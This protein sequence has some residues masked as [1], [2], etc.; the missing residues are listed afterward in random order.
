MKLQKAT[1]IQLVESK[2][3]GKEEARKLVAPKAFSILKNPQGTLDFFRKI[4]SL[5]SNRN[6]DAKIYL[7]V[8]EV[9]YL[10]IDAIMYTLALMYN[11]KRGGPIKYSFSGNLPIAKKPREMMEQCG[12]LNYVKSQNVHFKSSSSYIQIKTGRDSDGEVASEIVDFIKSKYKLEVKQLSFL[13]K[14]LIE[15]MANAKNHA[16]DHPKNLFKK[17]WYVFVEDA[18]GQIK[19]TFLDTGSGI[20]NT[21]RKKMT[22]KVGD[23]LP[24]SLRE[25]LGIYDYRY[26]KSALDAEWRTKTKLLYRGK[27]LPKIN[28]INMNGKIRDLSIISGKG[29]Y[30]CDGDQYDMDTRLFGT[31]FY[32]EVDPYSL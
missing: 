32:W 26:I 30:V 29:Y 19:F 21:V 14:M 16:Y 1:N 28:E 18:G 9:E 27:G 10:S 24:G 13:Y 23:L 7:D 3:I 2:K 8:S 6:S 4:I 31:L 20:P 22:E 25:E 5:V 17:C 11:L 12:F 15:L